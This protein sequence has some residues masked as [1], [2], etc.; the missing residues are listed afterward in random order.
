MILQSI[1]MA[2]ESI[3][4][5]KIRSFLTMLGIIIGVIALVV[6]VSLVSSA[7]DSVTEQVSTLGTD[8]LTAMVI[9]DKGYPLKLD[10][11]T[12]LES[13]SVMGRSRL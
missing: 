3:T 5:N 10:D 9:D 4:S 8:M 7:S 12:L 13:N 11:L 6:L 1:R 2:F